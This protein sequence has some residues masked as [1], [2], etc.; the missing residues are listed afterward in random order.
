M[1]SHRLSA[2]AVAELVGG[3]LFGDGGVE[4]EELAP[5]DRAGAHALTFL[6]SERY[7]PEYRRSH[8]GAVLVAESLAE[9]AR[10]SAT[11]II[12][13]DMASALHRVAAFFTPPAAAVEGIHPSAQLGANV[14]IGEGVSI[15]P[16]VVVEDRARIGPGTRLEA[17]VFLAAEVEIGADCVLGPHAVCYPGARLGNRVWL[18]A[19][20]VIGGTGFGFLPTPKGHQRMPHQGSC[21]L[22]D[23]VEVGSH[24]C[25]DRGTFADTIIGRG[26][27]IDNLVQ[28]GHNVRVGARC[29]I[30][31][32]T[33]IAGSVQIGNDVVIAGAVGIADRAVIGDGAT[34][35][36]RSVVF[37]PSRIEAGSVVGGY[38]ARPH[39]EFLRAQAAL[40][41]L[42][43]L[44]NRLEAVARGLPADASSDA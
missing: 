27:K 34:I 20:A 37:G 2:Q 5:L 15:G 39:R 4:L 13:A 28:I 6:V 7:L 29:L 21:I 3:R 36:A 40:Y 30:M 12:V 18:K 25:I 19:G 44:V 22:E 1:T 31:A 38:P 24:S 17:G 32:T 14:Q 35:S 33:G 41:R 42:A 11:R 8:A 10:G 23:D 43:P 16:F 9:A 26:T